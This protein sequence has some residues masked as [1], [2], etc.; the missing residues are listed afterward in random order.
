[1]KLL[2]VDFPNLFFQ[3]VIIPTEHLAP[4]STHTI[5]IHHNG[6]DHYCTS[7]NIHRDVTVYDSLNTPPSTDLIAQ[8]TRIYSD[9]NHPPTTQQ[10]R[11]PFR[12][13][14][15]R[16]CGLFA[17]AY[18]VDL[19]YGNDPSKIRYDQ[20]KFRQHF[21]YC[22]ENVKILPFPKYRTCPQT[23]PRTTEITG[24]LSKEK[25]W[26]KPRSTCKSPTPQPDFELELTNRFNPLLEGNPNKSR[27][28]TTPKKST[29]AHEKN[30]TP[31]S[32]KTPPKKHRPVHEDNPTKSSQ[33][34][35]LA[36]EASTQ[37]KHT[38]TRV[39]NSNKSRSNPTHNVINLSRRKLTKSEESVLDMGLSFC[40]STNQL[41]KEGLC[42]DFHKFIRR[43]RL[44]D[45]FHDKTEQRPE[46]EEEDRAPVNWLKSNPYWYPPYVK[47][48]CRKALETFITNIT[49]DTHL[50][51]KEKESKFWNNLS[52]EQRRAM[53]S[54]ANDND[55]VIK[56]SDKSGGIVILNKDDYERECLKH[57]TNETF[58]EEVAEDPTPVYRS[59]I[60]TLTDS[61]KEDG[62]ISSV[63]EDNLKKGNRTPLFYTLP[64]V[65]KPHN[66]IP[67]SRPICSGSDS[68]TVMCSELVD[69]FLKPAA[70]NTDS[71]LKDTTDFLN[72]LESTALP[73]EKDIFLVSSD[74]ES[75]Y[76]N[77]CHNEGIEACREYL[78]KRRNQRFPTQKICDL[79][80]TILTSNT[81]Q[82]KN[83]FFHQIKGTAMGT[84]MAVN[85]ANL[86]MA[87]FEKSMLEEY[88]A[89]HGLS[90]FA[91]YRYIDDIF[92]IWVGS[93]ESLKHFLTFMN[94]FSESKS[95]SSLIKFQNHY[96]RESTTFLDTTVKLDDDGI[97]TT[98]YSKPTASHDYL[99]R[100]SY[101]PQHLLKGIPK[102]QFMRL[103][104]ICSKIQDYTANA[105][106]LVKHFRRRGY[107]EADL[108][109]ALN[110][111]YHMDRKT[112]LQYRKKVPTDR[113]P[114]VLTYN[115][116]LNS[117]PTILHRNYDKM[118]A[119]DPS[120]KEVYPSPPI[121]SYRKPKNLSAW[122]VRAN[123]DR[124]QRQNN[125]VSDKQT[126]SELE[127]IMNRTGKITNPQNNITLPIKG[128]SA[129]E[130]NVVYAALCKKHQ[131]LCVGH[132]TLELNRRFN[133]HRSDIELYPDKCE[134]TQ[135]FHHNNCDFRKDLEVSI[136][137]PVDGSLEK[138][139]LLEDK[140]IVRLDTKAPNGMNEKLSD[141]GLLYYK[142]FIQP[143]STNNQT[144]TQSQ[145]QPNGNN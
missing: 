18:A 34:T 134:L 5:H 92:F 122:F 117:L 85:Y 26:H 16:D 50:A 104:R 10:V 29:P 118:V 109:K 13:Q 57:L 136:L 38:A 91:W 119:Q 30:H 7:T 15:G 31:G 82:F 63:E 126:A 103:R 83:R 12:Q 142:L 2:S 53:V 37:H 76:T 139:L 114:L 105:K 59:N 116:K 66:G 40:P 19:A 64:K 77:I 49:V 8:I 99:H 89:K 25:K 125:F 78:N 145:S 129:T 35:P 46:C 90:P 137:G 121:V 23:S 6:H 87:K 69:S 54:L 52:N 120:L 123:H 94:A 140:W 112:L 11:I 43:L 17:L 56:P 133:L 144:P 14:G 42:L 36:K 39:T 20:A 72:H 68:P 84:P 111:V 95:M 21:Q 141:Y 71:Y 131:L 9:D 45:Y 130:K 62:L 1:M 28:T 98:L 33:K 101:H 24:H 51:L 88:K 61:L 32:Q 102:G 27:Q 138:R 75:L 48:N 58:Y 143:P 79:L 65:H 4:T 74:V 110:E 127:D 107:N 106:E 93:E 73:K 60:D 22:L 100:T 86:F 3:E 67:P 135:H 97:S 128:G 80:R 96:S 113:V 41:D 124:P 55:I 70:Q 108:D 47:N 132:T 44:K 81:M 115:H